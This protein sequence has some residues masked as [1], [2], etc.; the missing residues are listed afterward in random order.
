MVQK[1]EK[2]AVVEGGKIDRQTL[3]VKKREK[4]RI[5]CPKCSEMMDKIPSKSKKLSRPYF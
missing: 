4:S 2:I 1:A 3:S 5:L